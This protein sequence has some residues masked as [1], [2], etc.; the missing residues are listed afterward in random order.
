MRWKTIVAIVLGAGMAV[1]AQAARVKVDGQ[2]IHYTVRGTG[3][4]IIF[5][6]GWTYDES[7]WSGQAPA[8]ARSYR[9]ITLDLPGHG[10]SDLPARG[11]YSMNPFADAVEA[12][13]VAARIDRAV[14]V[15]HS[16]GAGVVRNYA[17]K[18]P[19]HVAGLVAIDGLLDV[20]PFAGWPVD[21][22]PMT[23][24]ARRRLVNSMFVPETPEPLRGVIRRIM[25]GTPSATANGSGGSMFDAANQSQQTISA[26]ALT[27]F[28]GKPLFQINANTKE[29]LPNWAW[30]QV[31][32]AGHFVMLERPAEVNRLIATFLADKAQY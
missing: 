6:H 31:G 11:D 9:V 2:S 20:R 26:P 16:M 29:M 1:Q 17:L 12:V 21:R 7:S 30:S 10:K 27:I 13:R 3:K 18:H 8:F 19:D 15:G 32:G 25:L 4:A 22:T 24:D 5:V 14:L 28:A 23:L